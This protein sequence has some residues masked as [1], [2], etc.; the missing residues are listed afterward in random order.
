MP[1]CVHLASD[2][3]LGAPGY[4][5]S[6]ERERDFVRWMRQAARGEGFAEGRTATEIHLV[7]DMFDFW[8][9][10]RRAVPK[11]GVRLL[12]AMAELA[13]EGLPLHFHVGNHDMWTF[14]Y[15]EDELGVHVHRS[16]ILREWDG[17]SC[18]IG[19]G[20][21]LGPGDRGYHR[22]KR[23]FASPLCQRAFRAVHPDLGIAL[24]RAWS[25][26]SRQ[27]GEAAL[28]DLSAEH[29]HGFAKEWLSNESNARVDVFVFGHRH[30]PLDV[31]VEG[32][33]ARYLNTGDWL[34]HRSSVVI[35]DGQAELLLHSQ[36]D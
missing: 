13:D 26:K 2:L 25:S 15:L 14:G 19:H 4:A 1:H 27:K 18:M 32:T 22:L 11:G 9:E 20:D 7:G 12:G 3:H 33:Q 16:P 29:L 36:V 34:T 10:Y 17:L 5:S 24:A 30:L 31:P 23:L 28:R 35:A 8:F 6:V 21:G